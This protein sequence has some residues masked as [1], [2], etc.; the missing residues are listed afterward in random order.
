MV[1]IKKGSWY[2]TEKATIS[3]KGWT[4]GTY[5][6]DVKPVKKRRYLMLRWIALFLILSVGLTGAALFFGHGFNAKSIMGL[7]MLSVITYPATGYY[8]KLLK[9]K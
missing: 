5:G 2:T 1:K 9:I 4:S 7:M 6:G 8:A 3:A